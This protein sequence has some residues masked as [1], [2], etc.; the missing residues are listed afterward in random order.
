MS[1]I[2]RFPH[3]LWAVGDVGECSRVFFMPFF[4][5]RFDNHAMGGVYA[6]AR[7]RTL[8]ALY[9]NKRT[10]TPIY[11][12]LPTPTYYLYWGLGG[13]SSCARVIHHGVPKRP[14]DRGAELCVTSAK[15]TSS[16]TIPSQNLSPLIRVLHRL[17]VGNPPE[18]RHRHAI[19]PF[20]SSQP[21]ANMVVH[22][23]AT[24]RNR[25]NDAVTT[26]SRPSGGHEANRHMAAVCRLAASHGPSTDSRQTMRHRHGRILPQARNQIKASLSAFQR[27][28]VKVIRARRESPSKTPKE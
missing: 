20:P 18:S 6:R 9:R 12:L 27:W 7:A 23:V 22:G 11:T 2:I 8:R 14:G 26:A 17:S 10:P 19:W 24:P 13:S 16:F 5:T 15:T 4:T 28:K 25:W 1:E 3:E 21:P